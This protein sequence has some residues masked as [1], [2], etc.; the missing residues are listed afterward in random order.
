MHVDMNLY[1]AFA[2]NL[3]NISKKL[4]KDKFIVKVLMREKKPQMYEG[5]MKS[6]RV[7]K[8]YFTN[9]LL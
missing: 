6:K 4:S 2:G 8:Y 1:M 3:E 5:K 9:L 7:C